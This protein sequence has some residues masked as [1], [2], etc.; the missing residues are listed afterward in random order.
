MIVN[1]TYAPN[2]SNAPV[3]FTATLNAVANFFQSTFSDPVTVNINVGFGTVNGQ[4]LSGGALGESLTY[5][6]NYTYSQLKTALAADAKTADDTSSVNSLPVNDPTGGHYWV[7]TAEAKA[8]GLAGASSALDGYIGFSNAAG[9]FDYDNSNGV[10]PGNMTSSRSSPMKCRKSWDGS[11]WSVDRSAARRTVTSRWTCSI[12]RHPA[13]TDSQVLSQGIFQSITAPR[14]WTISTP[15]PTA[16][17]GIG[18]LARA[19]TRRWPLAI[20]AW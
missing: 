16:I 15:I 14:I 12:S 20:P 8:L 5:L 7:S 3:G 11:C 19:M 1:F 18:P 4:S 10:S 6:S 9:I 2:V 17:S 13:F